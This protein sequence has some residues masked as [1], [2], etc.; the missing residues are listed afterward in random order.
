M[1][2]LR[3]FSMKSIQTA[4]KPSQRLPTMMT[5]HHRF[6]HRSSSPF[7]KAT[8]ISTLSI[9]ANPSFLSSS[10][11]RTFSNMHGHPY[12]YFEWWRRLFFSHWEETKWATS[13]ITV[14]SAIVCIVCAWCIYKLCL[15]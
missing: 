2:S 8:R 15:S 1:N 13:C 6:I 14:S 11:S 5:L 7:S 12:G 10:Q 9:N 4:I 3:H